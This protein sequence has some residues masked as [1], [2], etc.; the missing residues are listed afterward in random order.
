MPLGS[1]PQ[2]RE[3]ASGAHPDPL[4]CRCGAQGKGRLWP[5]PPADLPQQDPQ[6]RP[7]Q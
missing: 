5:W 3:E 6:D 1:W 7:G 4:T 2:A